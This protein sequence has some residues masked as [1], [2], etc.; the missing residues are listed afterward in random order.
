MR[1]SVLKIMNLY[2]SSEASMTFSLPASLTRETIPTADSERSR[3]QDMHKIDK[4]HAAEIIQRAWRSQTDKRLFRLL[5]HAARAAEHCASHEILKTVSPLEAALLRDPS[6]PHKVRFRFAGEE[7]PPFIVFKIFH[8]KSGGGNK[9]MNGKKSILAS[10][11]A[12][13]DACKLMGHRIFYSQIIGDQLLHQK[14][15]ITDL[16]DIATMKDYM[17]YLSN[18]DETPAY[19]GGRDNYWRKLSLK[20]LSRTTIMYDI[21][22]YAQSGK[23]SNRLQEE[24]K[25]L[26]L[27]PQN[28]EAQYKQM[29]AVTRV[30]SPMPPPTSLASTSRSTHQSASSRLSARRS[31]HALQKVAKM[32]R[33]YGQVKL[34]EGQHSETVHHANQSNLIDVDGS[35]MSPEQEMN[36]HNILS[37]EDWEE[38][39]EKLYAWTQKLTFEDG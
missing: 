9:Y 8:C 24:L 19:L 3:Y 34:K 10:N 25:F 7:F 29:A 36:V 22:D 23:L 12:A 20:N 38:E 28:E 14:Q 21:V 11:E 15:K 6:V 37:D 17:Q 18:L 39:A 1:L 33:V 35:V 26:L 30:R 13:A 16:I 4:R 31:H 2:S 32:R 5:K 27:K